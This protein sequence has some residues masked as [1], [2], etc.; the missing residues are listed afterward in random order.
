MFP[1]ANLVIKIK[2]LFGGC[3]NIFIYFDI[4]GLRI[5]RLISFRPD[6][7]CTETYTLKMNSWKKHE[8]IFV[9]LN[10]IMYELLMKVNIFMSLGIEAV[11]PSVPYYLMEPVLKR[12]T[13]SQLYRIEDFN[14]VSIKC[15][16]I[17]NYRND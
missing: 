6:Q 12:C 2:I 4:F 7:T 14:P 9:N 17:R 13:P 8:K 15:K 16:H 11:G 10:F 5:N 1:F 3:C